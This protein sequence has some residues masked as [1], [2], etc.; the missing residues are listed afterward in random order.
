MRAVI[1]A[2][3][4]A[5]GFD[6]QAEEHFAA[7]EVGLRG[8]VEDVLFLDAGSR[9]RAEIFYFVQDFGDAGDVEFDF[10]FRVGLFGFR[11]GNSIGRLSPK[12]M[13]R[14]EQAE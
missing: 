11:H 3:F 8:V 12:L 9:R 7:A 2:F 14:D 4:W 10:D 5:R 13:K 6:A 1:G